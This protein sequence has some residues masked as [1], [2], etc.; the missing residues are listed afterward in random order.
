[1]IKS[2]IIVS[3]FILI[4]TILF[5]KESLIVFNF[6]ILSF[7]FK[8]VFVYKPFVC[9]STVSEVLSHIF[10]L[11]L[12]IKWYKQQQ[13][14]NLFLLGTFKHEKVYCCY[15]F[16]RNTCYDT[17]ATIMM[18]FISLLFEGSVLLLHSPDF[19]YLG[20]Y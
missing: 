1:M 15:N 19:F 16:Y 8:N 13:Q 2:K 3:S 6:L 5:F 10:L 14:N 4:Q 20:F 7:S 9:F 17:T 11:Q 12:E 18:N